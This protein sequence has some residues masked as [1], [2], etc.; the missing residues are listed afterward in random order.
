MKQNRLLQFLITVVSD[1]FSVAFKELKSVFSDAGVIIFFIVVPLAYPM[2]YAFIYNNEVVREVPMVVV[3]ENQSAESR[4]FI[5]RMDAAPDLHVVSHCADINEAKEQLRLKNAYGV[6]LIPES[7]SRNIATG[8][9]SVVSLYSDMSSLLFYKA[10]LITASEVSLDMG[11]KIRVSQQ[12]LLTEEQS[13]RQTTPVRYESVAMYNP[14][15]GF[16]SFLVPAILVL[17]LQQTLLL[18]VGMLTGTR[19]NPSNHTFPI[20]FEHKR[21]IGTF[22]IVAGKAFTYL[23]IYAVMCVWVLRIVPSIFSFPMIGHPTD[24]MLFLLPYLLAAIFFAI[25]LSGLVRDRETPML[26]FVFTSVPLIFLSGVSWPQAAIPEG[27]RWFSY[28]FPSTFGVQ[29]F[30]K[31]N[32]MGADFWQVKTEYLALWLQTAVYFG[33]ACLTYHYFLK[34]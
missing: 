6:L 2:L 19:R 11:K 7:F 31:I 32:T 21:F 3:D 28:L 15:S 29:G 17:L 23:I 12:Q 34:K 30:L 13:M 27:W 1:L 5:R 22:R 16:A 20:E 10:M 26:L 9:Q 33:T 4:D 24:L 8:R 18:G 14:Q 25:T